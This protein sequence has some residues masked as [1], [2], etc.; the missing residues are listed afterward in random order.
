MSQKEVNKM[1][2]L[3]Q[4]NDDLDSGELTPREYE[5]VVNNIEEEYEED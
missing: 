3:E 5:N 1:Y 2:A 4:A